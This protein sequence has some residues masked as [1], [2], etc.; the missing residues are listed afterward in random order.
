MR[1]LSLFAAIN[2]PYSS[3]RKIFRKSHKN[4]TKIATDPGPDLNE[5]IPD[6][7]TVRG[8]LA[9]SVRRCDLLRSLLRVSLRKAAYR[10]PA[11]PERQEVRRAHA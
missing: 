9:D 11:A 1:I 3:R 4:Q 5:L 7:D 8:M 2:I 10:H 6:P